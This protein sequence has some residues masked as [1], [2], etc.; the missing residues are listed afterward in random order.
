MGRDFRLELSSQGVYVVPGEVAGNIVVVTDEAKS[1]NAISI[2]LR[3]YA[4]VH[5]TETYTVN[6]QHGHSRT[7][8]RHYHSHHDY[9]NDS[10]ILWK[11]EQVPNR[12]LNPGNYVLPFRFMLSGNLPSSF[13]GQYGHIR[14]ELEARISTGLFHFDKTV[15]AI[16]QV[17]DRVDINVPALMSPVQYEDEKTLLSLS[18]SPPI[19][20]TVNVPRTGFCIGEGI[21][22]TASLDNGS[23][24]I[25]TM[26]AT[27]IKKVTFHAQGHTKSITTELN[28]FQSPPVQPGSTYQWAPCEQLTISSA[29]PTIANCDIIRLGYTL[30]IEVSIPWAL[31]AVINIP[32]TLGN[33]PSQS[34]AGQPPLPPIQ[35]PS[36]SANEFVP[37]NPNP[38]QASSPDSPPGPPYQGPPPGAPYPG[39]PYQAAPPGVPPAGGPF[40]VPPPGAYP[41]GPPPQY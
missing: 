7:E 37:Y 39:A 9:I 27:P 26:K 40:Q 3:G 20:L 12:V 36:F 28:A 15:S 13:A 22:L 19:S 34:S 29:I 25:I 1:Y 2:T 14:Y 38:A 6:D 35:Y 11:K 18:A 4:D 30:R 5:W 31:D 41:P 17:V 23:G 32:F 21:P 16:I 33:V 10:A 24:R 8:T